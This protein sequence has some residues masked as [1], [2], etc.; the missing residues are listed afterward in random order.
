MILILIVKKNK[1]K[2]LTVIKHNKFFQ[3]DKNV[4]Q[5]YFPNLELYLTFFLLVK[6]KNKFFSSK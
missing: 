6:R 3:T 5:I 2:T 4:H 1:G